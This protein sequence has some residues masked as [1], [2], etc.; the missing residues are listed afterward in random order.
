M[1]LFSSRRRAITAKAAELV[2][3]FEARFGRAPNALELDRLQRQATFADPAGE[4]ATT[5]RPARSCSTG[6]TRE[7]RADVA[8]GLAEVAA[9][10]ARRRAASS[11]RPQAWSPQAVIET[12]LADVQQRKAAWTRA[13]LTRAIN[14][15]LPDHL[16]DL[17]G[18]DVARLLDGLTDAGAGATRA[19]RRAHRPGDDAAARR[20]AAGQRRSR[21]TQAPGSDAVR[22]PGARAHRAR[23]RRGRRAARRRG[24]AAAESRSGSSTTCAE[25]GHRARRRPGR[26]RARRP[27]L[28]R[29]GRVA[30]RPGRTGKSFVVGALGQGLDRTRPCGAGTERRVFGLATR[31]IATDVLAGEGLTAPQHRP[32]ARHPG[33]ARRRPRHRGRRRRRAWRLRAGDLVVVDESAMTDTADLA[34][35]HRHVEAAGAKLLL[36]GDHRQL[37]AVGAGGGMD[38]LADA[39]ARYELAEA[40]RFD[41]RVGARGVAAAARRRRDR[42]ARVP[43][44][45]PAPRR[46]H[47]RAGRGAAARAWLA[48]TL[49]GQ[50]V[51]A[52]RRHQ[53]AG[54]PA[55]RAAARRAGPP[56]PRRRGRRAARPARAPSPGSA[57]S[58]R[59]G[60]TAGTSPGYEGNRRG[61]I[62]RETYRVTAV[63]D[64]GGLDVARRRSGPTSR[65]RTADAARLA[66]SP[67]TWRSAT[68]PPC[69]PRRAAP[70]TPP[71]RRHRRD[72][73]R[74]RSTSA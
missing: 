44:A 38:L 41:P 66:T 8:G 22:H 35:I 34:A 15:A 16:G 70:S 53:R 62:N 52:D 2:A 26:R 42:A 63:R 14:D 59:P 61:P 31:Q 67:S 46:R 5:A 11:R 23:A 68:P 25:S 64:D 33:P 71:H 4:V 17:D 9:R 12:A 56:R 51:A 36:V 3:A 73:R 40:R 58:S 45:R 7:L 39:G 55:V 32:L 21:P 43:Q 28:R 6:G 54:R 49:A 69:T 47:R 72:R 13:D 18:A 30:G 10:R 48:D 37:A 50:H 19:A 60:S 57:T 65:G 29:A 20:A 74:P 1:D 24:A 27:H